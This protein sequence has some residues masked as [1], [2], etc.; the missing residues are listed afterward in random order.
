[1]AI[2]FVFVTDTFGTKAAA[3]EGA[4]LE[5]VTIVLAR[6]NGGIDKAVLKKKLRKHDGGTEIRVLR[7]FI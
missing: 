5:G 4:F 6:F 3:L 2:T 7:E 1:M